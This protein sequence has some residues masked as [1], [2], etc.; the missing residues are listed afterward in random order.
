MKLKAIAA[1]FLL[2]ALILGL[3]PAS[4]PA[5]FAQ[6][7]V[8]SHQQPD[9]GAGGG[10][11]AASFGTFDNPNYYYASVKVAPS[12][13]YYRQAGLSP[14]GMKVVAQKSWNDGTY[15]RVEVVLM[16]ADGTNEAVIS[17]GDSGQGDI[18]Q[19]GN[20]F[21]SD[22]GTAVGYVEA[23]VSNPN[24]VVRYNL[25]DSTR[26]YIY[27]PD[28]M[29]AN[30]CDFLGSSKTSIVCWDWIEDDGA[31][32]LFI[33]DGSERTYITRSTDYSEYEP[34]SNGDGTVVVYWSGETTAEPVNTTHTLTYSGGTWT[35]DVGFTPIPD[36]Y[37]SGWSGRADN[38]IA[39]TVMSS[40][41]ILIYDSAGT[42]VTD[43]TGPGYSGGSGQW[44]FF[45]VLAEG[46]NGNWVITSN[47]ARADAGRDIVCAASRLHMYVAPP[48]LGSDANCG[49]EAAPFATVQKG[50]AEVASGGTVHV[51]AGT[52]PEPVNIENRADLTIK[53][54]DKTTTIIKPTSTLG[55]NVGTYGSSRLTTFRVV[56]STNVTVQNLTVDC[57]LVKTNFLWATLF[58]DS[59]GTLDNNIIQNTS[60][61]DASGYYYEFGSAFR[62]PGFTDA[63][64]A[65]VTVSNN[66]YKDTGRIGIHAHDY[67]HLSITGNQIY[68]TTD[69]FGYGM[70]IGSQST[71]TISGNTIYGYDTPAATDQSQSGGIYI[72]NAFTS[73]SPHVTKNVSLSGN[74]VYDC[75]WALYIGN[76]FDGYAGDVDI[77]VAATGNNFHDNIDG[78]VALADEDKAA[79]SSVTYTGSGNALTNNGGD[80]YYIST[81]GDGDMTVSLENE[82]ISGQEVG[83]HLEDTDTSP[84]SGSSYNI[85][86]R[87]CSIAG[88]TSYGVQNEYS[89]TMID[90][91]QNYW[92]AVSGPGPVALGSGDEVST[93]VDYE[94]WCNA[95]FSFCG[96]TTAAMTATTGDALFCV[97]ENTTVNLNLADVAQLYGYQFEVTYDASKASA[98][99]YFDNGFFNTASPALIATGYNAQCSGGVCKFGVSHVVPQTAV[100]GSG[101]L[102]HIVFTGVAPGAFNVTI[103]SDAILADRDGELLAREVAAPLPLTVCGSTTVSGKV[104]MQGRSAGNVN[105]G[106]VTL[107]DL[108][109]DFPGPFSTSFSATDG[110]FSLSV[111]VMPGGSSYRMDAAHALY[112]TNEKTPVAL[113]Y[114]VPLA[115]QNTRLWGGDA[116]NGGKVEIGDL[117]CIGGSFGLTPSTCGGLGS[118]DI[119]ADSV[120]NVQDLA[121]AGGNFD[122]ISPQLW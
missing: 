118:A 49:T 50:V 52:Y 111:P 96:Y 8:I 121:I 69:D 25:A 112:L 37:W 13:T 22:D 11:T 14:D 4:P 81:A 18:Q 109:G 85:D 115:G 92:G 53:G 101:Q 89:G 21:W 36:S 32:D 44:N 60:L 34:V 70:E 71:A 47:A 119:N 102:A 110:A 108:G 113:T 24:K 3:T 100:S 75:Q 117:S 1:S 104:T 80:G 106:T 79:G 26:T 41:D 48:P 29:D 42:L 15:N 88:N 6:N 61:P 74:E 84:P 77:V 27:E 23:H 83:I 72:E 120:V 38:H 39:T 87:H 65:S 59:T 91:E 2:V 19:Y 82:T 31:A 94:P 43:L 33:W 116:N 16:N 63:A 67:V 54:E 64:R 57:D 93:N 107:T 68:K 99:G 28:G 7:K 114:G 73:A 10:I 98:A 66:I 46:P 105:S 103:G 45:G 97:G 55:W 30:N 62:A 95:D 40:K 5:A 76:E 122:K 17:P 35:K 58:W 20:P 86:V 78:A 90:A 56:N 12:G 9:D 51:A